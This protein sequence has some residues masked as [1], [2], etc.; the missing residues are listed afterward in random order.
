VYDAE[1]LE[2]RRAIDWNPASGQVEVSAVAV[3]TG[4]DVIWMTDWTNGGYIYR[5]SLTSGQYSGKMR[6]EP[7]LSA[8]QGIAVHG[9][10]LYITTDDGD[11]EL[12]EADGLWQVRADP[13]ADENKA[14][15]IKAFTEFRR[16]GEVE[17]LDFDPANKELVVLNNRGERII[18]GMPSGLYPGYDR[19]IH[20]LYIYRL[21]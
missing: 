18:K 6:L 3:D 1:T 8:P 21:R 9:G 16:A 15:R 17:G 2:Y 20:E 14:V 11:A 19:E 12:A 5:Y 4:N 10:Y 13:V 7:A